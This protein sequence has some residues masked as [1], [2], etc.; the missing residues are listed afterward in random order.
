M[1]HGHCFVRIQCPGVLII[2]ARALVNFRNFRNFRRDSFSDSYN[3]D[4]VHSQSKC[5]CCCNELGLD[6]S[7]TNSEKAV[8]TM[9]L[10]LMVM[11][12]VGGAN[13]NYYRRVAAHAQ[14]HGPPHEQARLLFPDSQDPRT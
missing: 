10:L 12:L 11:V 4:C 9:S 1:C 6:Y 13:S 2:S 14:P 3:C 8:V 7:Y 5:N